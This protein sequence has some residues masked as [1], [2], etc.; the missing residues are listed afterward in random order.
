VRGHGG[1]EGA[2]G[3]VRRLLGT[4]AWLRAA[5]RR[6]LQAGGGSGAAPHLAGRPESAPRQQQAQRASIQRFQARAKP[7][8]IKVSDNSPIFF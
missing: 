2:T 6:R 3:R 1:R 7:A 4:S 5:A 8:N